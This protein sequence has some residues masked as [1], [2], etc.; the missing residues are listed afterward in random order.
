MLAT[1]MVKLMLCD[2]PA[3]RDNVPQLM[4]VTGLL[5]HDDRTPTRTLCLRIVTPDLI[6]LL[7]RQQGPLVARM[8][9]LPAFLAGTGLTLAGPFGFLLR[10][11]G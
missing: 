3:R 7:L 10:G 8:A 5:F 2:L 6:D 4:P 1:A 11:V 9:G